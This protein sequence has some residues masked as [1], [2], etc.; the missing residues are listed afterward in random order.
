MNDVLGLT[1]L[2]FT[3]FIG[4]LLLGIGGYGNM[5]YDLPYFKN[6]IIQAETLCEPNGGMKTLTVS[7]RK[8][9]C[10]NGANFEVEVK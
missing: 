6:K 10:N 8:I 3:M 5:G 2:C 9:I 1:I 7:G 4:G